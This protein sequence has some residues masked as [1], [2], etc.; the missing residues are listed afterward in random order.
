[1]DADWRRVL[2]AFGFGFVLEAVLADALASRSAAFA[3]LSMSRWYNRAVFLAAAKQV[4]QHL[5]AGN[6]GFHQVTVF[7]LLN[8]C[9]GLAKL[10]T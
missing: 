6:D 2:V 1:M 7:Q 9:F 8:F 4:S 3:A 5:P 10:F